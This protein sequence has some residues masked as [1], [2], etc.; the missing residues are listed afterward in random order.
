VADLQV[1]GAFQLFDT[2]QALDALTRVLPVT[3]LYR[4]RYWV[5]I[6]LQRA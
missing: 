3:I 1:S 4:T 2:D 6:A 5:T